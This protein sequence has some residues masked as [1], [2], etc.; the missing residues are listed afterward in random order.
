MTTWELKHYG[1]PDSY[2]RRRLSRLPLI[3]ML[4]EHIP[5][6]KQ[7]IPGN[8]S[9]FGAITFLMQSIR[10]NGRTEATNSSSVSWPFTSISST[11]AESPSLTRAENCTAPQNSSKR[12]VSS[13][14]PSSGELQS[15]TSR[16]LALCS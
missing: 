10:H 1:L 3:N 12:F 15:E 14:F 2:R 5:H 13:S 11:I 4:W 9:P 7:L 16:I 8:T 6:L